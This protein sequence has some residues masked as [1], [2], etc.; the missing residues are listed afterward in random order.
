MITKNVS[1]YEKQTILEKT[2]LNRT[3]ICKLFNLS[4]RVANVWIDKFI[5][6]IGGK[7]NLPGANLFPTST[8]IEWAKV[9]FSLIID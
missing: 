8:F 6:E 4:R 3:D 1:K 7:Q 5:K 9:D 2:Y